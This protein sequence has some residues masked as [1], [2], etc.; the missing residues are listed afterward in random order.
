MDIYQAV[1]SSSTASSSSLTGAVSSKAN[2]ASPASS[3]TAVAKPTQGF[4]YSGCYAEPLNRHS[5]DLITANDSMSVEFCIAAARSQLSAKPATTYRYIGVEYGR[6]CWG[7][8]AP[9]TSQTSLIGNNACPMPCAGN[10]TES[11]G[12][13]MMY[14]YYITTDVTTSR[15]A[16]IPVSTTGIMITTTAS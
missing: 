16:S 2:T 5:M 10:N 3:T 14:N 8:T 11:C 12:G 9:V 7:A 6:E 15:S 13:G 1:V 4:F